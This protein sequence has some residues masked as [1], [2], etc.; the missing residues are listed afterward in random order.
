[1]T[2]PNNKTK[3]F[4]AFKAD[5][6][7]GETYLYFRSRSKRDVYVK[8][9]PGSIKAGSETVSDYNLKWL[10]EELYIVG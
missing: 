2:N 4:K 10:E 3:L 9:T 1:M 8:N 6:I 7:Y 5:D